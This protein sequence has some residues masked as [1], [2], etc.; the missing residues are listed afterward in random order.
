[1]KINRLPII[2]I[3]AAMVLAACSGAGPSETQPPEPQAMDTAQ[4]APAPTES[5]TMSGRDLTAIMVCELVS[6]EEVAGL[7]GGTVARPPTGGNDG[8]LAGC[9]Y[10]IDPPGELSYHYYIVYVMPPEFAEVTINLMEPG[11]Y[12]AVSGLDGQAYQ[13]YE[14]V[15]QQFRLILLRPQD[16][17]M[18]IIGSD[19][20]VMLKLAEILVER[21]R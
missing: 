19:Q 8:G 13:K 10:E 6:A 16:Y 4:L 12:E 15:E 20:Q 11:E 14:E 18:E 9:T 21:L 1:M 3:L 7:A 2:L 17:G 5:G